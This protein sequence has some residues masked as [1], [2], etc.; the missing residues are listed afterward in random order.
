[1]T[2]KTVFIIFTITNVVT[3]LCIAQDSTRKSSLSKADSLYRNFEEKEALQLYKSVLKRQPDNYTALWRS[4]F[5]FSRIGYRLETEQ[6]KRIY[7]N[8]AIEL[9]ERALKVDSTDTQSNF[10]MAAALGRKAMISGTQERVQA[11]R[12]IKRYAENAI[13]FDSTNAGA[14]HVLGRWHFKVAN[15]SDIEQLAANTLFGG[16]PEASEKKAVDFLEKA[17][18]LNSRHILYYYD[19]ARMYKHVGKQ[20]QA[21]RTCKQALKKDPLS[22]DDPDLKKKCKDLITTL[23]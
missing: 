13:R 15:L 9:A 4:S 16:I 19:L 7:Y 3:V 17:I 6:Q 22:P 1:M 8:R 2:A 11:S 18:E 5:L 12:L 23:E 20:E 10:V 21:I 14:W